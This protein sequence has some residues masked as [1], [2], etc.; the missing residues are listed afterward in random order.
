MTS[1][2]LLYLRQSAAGLG[3][4]NAWFSVPEINDLRDRLRMISRLGEFSTTQ[5]TL[6]G[7]GEPREVRSGV[8]DGHFFDVMGL[9][10]ALG[11]LIGPDDDGPKASGVVV[12][13]CDG[14]CSPRVWSSAA[15]VSSPG[16]CWP[17][18][19]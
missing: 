9:R 3:V 17:G 13:T 10:P 8:V 2:D 15:W 18:R 5:P 6:F 1:S 7:L 16:S 11:R 12:L 4:Q 14:R 19:S